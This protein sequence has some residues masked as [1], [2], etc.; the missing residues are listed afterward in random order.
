MLINASVSKVLRAGGK[1]VV[2]N[3]GGDRVVL[4]MVVVLS[5]DLVDKVTGTRLR[6]GSSSR[7]S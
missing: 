3:Q 7:G 6:G 1:S 5:Q 2:P 4:T